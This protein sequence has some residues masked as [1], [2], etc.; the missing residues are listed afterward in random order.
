KAT[1]IGPDGA[2]YDVTEAHLAGTYTL[3]WPT[4][5]REGRKRALAALGRW[6]WVGRATDDLAQQSSMERAFWVNDT[7]GYLQVAPRAVRLRARRRNSVVARFRLAHPAA[8]VGTI[9]TRIGVLVRRIGPVKLGAGTRSL[10]WNGRYRSGRLAYRGSYVF[11]VYAKN[12]YGPVTL[13]QTF[14][15]RR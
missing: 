12:S 14:G 13:A 5:T 10:R 1:I 15:V 7:L 4:G 6:R 9:A 2:A 8:V 3:K 11:S